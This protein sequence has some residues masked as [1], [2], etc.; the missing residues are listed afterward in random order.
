[1]NNKIAALTGVV[2]RSNGRPTNQSYDVFDDL[3]GQVQVQ[4]ANLREIMEIDVP[5][6]NQLVRDHDVPAVWVEEPK[7]NDDGTEQ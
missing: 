2:S 3:N 1:M 7:S 4:L 6:F 5:A